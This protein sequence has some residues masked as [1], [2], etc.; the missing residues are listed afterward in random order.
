MLNQLYLLLS[1][2]TYLLHIDLNVLL[3]VIAIQVEHK[4]VDKVETVAYYNQGELISQFGLLHVLCA[5]VGGKK[6]ERK[7]KG[8]GRRK[9]RG[10]GKGIRCG[11]INNRT[12]S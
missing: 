2:L 10:R 6:R 1:Q 9:N 4:V 5:C 7:K 8:G 12:I 3:Q 11:L